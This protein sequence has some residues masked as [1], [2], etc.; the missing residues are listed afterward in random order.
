MSTTSPIDF[1]SPSCHSPL[2]GSIADLFNIGDNATAVAVADL[3]GDDKTQIVARDDD[4]F[5]YE[6]LR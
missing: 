1:H 4:R 6:D 5:M 3:N 2:E